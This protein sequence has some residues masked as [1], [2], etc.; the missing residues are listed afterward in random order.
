MTLLTLLVCAVNRSDTI[1]PAFLTLSTLL[2]FLKPFSYIFW[3]FLGLFWDFFVQ[4]KYHV[5][6]V[7]SHMSHVIFHQPVTATA[8]D[9]SQLTPPFSTVDWFQILKKIIYIYIYWSKKLV[10][11]S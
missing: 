6:H 11:L 2:E 5:S 3:H 4:K 9:L 1:S 10:K 8:T 7:T